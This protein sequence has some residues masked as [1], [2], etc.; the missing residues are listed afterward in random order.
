MTDIQSATDENRRGNK[1]RR[2]N[3][4]GKI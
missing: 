4:R 2:R 1:E 3:H